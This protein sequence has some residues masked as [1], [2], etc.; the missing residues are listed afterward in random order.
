MT[1]A[2]TCCTSRPVVLCY[3]VAAQVKIEQKHLNLSK[4]TSN[5]IKTM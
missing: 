4:I 3:R 5:V 1:L 2:E